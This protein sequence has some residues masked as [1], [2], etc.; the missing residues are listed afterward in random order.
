M[1]RRHYNSGEAEFILEPLND[2]V[3][4]VTHRDQVGWFGISLDWDA[5]RPYT[6]TTLPSQLRD[7]GI[8]G[9]GF[10]YGTPDDALRALCARLLDQQRREDSRRINPEERKAAARRLLREFLNE[11][12][13]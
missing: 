7:D 4:K 11:Q 3:V 8:D 12:P 5:Q 1:K 6:S 9:M 10:Q 2:A 13:R